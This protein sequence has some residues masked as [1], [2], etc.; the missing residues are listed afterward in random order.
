VAEDTMTKPQTA[1]SEISDDVDPSVRP[2]VAFVAPSPRGPRVIVLERVDWSQGAP[3]V[4]ARE[5]A[6]ACPHALLR[7][8]TGTCPCPTIDR[9][10]FEIALTFVARPADPVK[11]WRMP[12]W[13]APAPQA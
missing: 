8:L 5:R 12:S 7:E 3:R 11:R 4:S 6:P 9:A 13:Y 10:A 2:G 1:G